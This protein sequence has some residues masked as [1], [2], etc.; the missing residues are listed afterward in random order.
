MAPSVSSAAPHPLPSIKFVREG[1]GSFLERRWLLPPLASAVIIAVILV[2]IAVHG[3]ALTVGKGQ[4]GG[5]SDEVGPGAALLDHAENRGRDLIGQ[6]NGRSGEETAVSVTAGEDEGKAAGGES[7]PRLP[8]F[9]Y[10]I[11]G[12]KGDGSRMKRLL[13]S[14]YHP[15]NEYLLHLDLE[16]PP[17]ERMDLARFLRMHPTFVDVGNVHLVAKANLVTYRG[18]TMIAAYLHCAAILLRQRADWDWFINLSASDYPLMT[19]DDMAYVFSYL[20]RELNFVDHSSDLGWKEYV[21]ARPIVVD[22]GIY[23]TKKA[24][25]FFT[26]QRRT[27]PTAFRLFQGSAWVV[28]SRA[29]VEYCIWGW[30]NLPRLTLMYYTNFVSSPEGYFQTV[31]CNSREFRNTTVNSDLHYILWDVPA[32]QHPKTLTSVYFPNMTASGVPFARKFARDG[33]V[34][35]RIDREL[36]HRLSPE[37]FTPGG[38]CAGAEGDSRKDPCWTT[39]DPT[40]LRPSAGAQRLQ[41]HMLK[42]LDAKNFRGKQCI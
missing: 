12:S 26:S 1:S 41:K 37:F 39:G 35:G 17:R 15:R 24:D 10:I 33:E 9:A 16:A 5:A 30:D 13:L 11:T 6:G 38:W 34:L 19:Q 29:F 20:P 8:V 28:L 7:G 27:V 22:P 14:L 3:F 36:L 18:P 21:R 23:S 40:L 31:I 25:L 32:L 4:W 42:L 2:V